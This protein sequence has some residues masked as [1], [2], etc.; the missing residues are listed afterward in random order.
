[1]LILMFS[2][3]NGYAGETTGKVHRVTFEFL[4]GGAIAVPSPLIIKQE[5]EPDLRFL[6]MYQTHSF[7][8]PIYYSW[9]LGYRFSS[10]S[11]FE[12]EMNHLKLYLQN[13]PP[14]IERFTITHGFNQIWLNYKWRKKENWYY[15]LGIGPVVAHPE[16]TIRGLKLDESQGIYGK[17]YYIAGITSQVAV[18]KKYY[19]GS[20][21]FVS[22]ES[23]INL[24]YARVKVVN[25]HAH[26][27]A[28]SLHGLAG[29]GV[30]F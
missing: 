30:S 28:I 12:L 29:I 24:A 5:G 27:P 6:A 3:G 8:L 20:H 4:P 15:T 23:K 2:I 25:G 1:M 7:S 19:W 22:L 21:F 16:N 13:K 14:E 9:R 17:G 11:W 18:Q 26:V 10:S